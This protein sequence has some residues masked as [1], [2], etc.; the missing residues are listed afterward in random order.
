M[1]YYFVKIKEYG[2]LLQ[3]IFVLYG[4]CS[5]VLMNL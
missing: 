3:M 5:E 1:E 4:R 2:M